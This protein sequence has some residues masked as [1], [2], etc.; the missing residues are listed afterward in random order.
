ME[1]GLTLPDIVRRFRATH[2][3]EGSVQL[4]GDRVRVTAQLIEAATDH[5]LWAQSY[6]RD[7]RDVWSLQDEIARAIAREVN[8]ELTSHESLRFEQSRRVD[9]NAYEAYLRGKFVMQGL[10]A[11]TLSQAIEHFKHA[12]QADP[13]LAPAY[14]AL[15]ES[16]TWAA[17]YGFDSGRR[18]YPFA[19][20]A[21]MKAVELDGELAETQAA[22]A[23][24]QSVSWDWQQARHSFDRA[25]ELNPGLSAIHDIYSR[26]WL[27]PRGEM[28]EGLAMAEQAVELDPLSAVRQIRLAHALGM[29]G[30]VQRS[31]DILE[32]VI[33][34]DPSPGAYLSIAPKYARAGRCTEALAATDM[35][36]AFGALCV[37]CRAIELVLCGKEAEARAELREIEQLA[38]RDSPSPAVD[39]KW[40]A[41]DCCAS[42]HGS[43]AAVARVYALLGEADEAFRWLER[44]YEERDIWM[45]WVKPSWTYDSLRSDVRYARLM[46]RMNLEP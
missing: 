33:E 26:Y 27:L 13:S 32:S 5:H 1:L 21:A 30:D 22:L 28:E 19:L 45:L 14:A 44:G 25:F 2:V 7:I 34:E 17:V 6:D 15:A 36:E 11:D 9:R 46:R 20:S 12:I 37:P 40:P 10:S 24:T 23:L 39:E 41:L 42:S 29:V 38:T 35:A 4:E 16:Y 18:V 8:I 3:L 43:P 31:I